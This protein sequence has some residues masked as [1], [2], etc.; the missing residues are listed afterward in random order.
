M[1]HKTLQ[2]H[3]ALDFWTA[4]DLKTQAPVGEEML[5]FADMFR[6][7][8]GQADPFGQTANQRSLMRFFWS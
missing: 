5:D 7:G 6:M 3:S 1:G 4:I 2:P 8:H